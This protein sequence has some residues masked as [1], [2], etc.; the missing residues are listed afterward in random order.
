[1]R[2]KKTLSLDDTL[3]EVT[4]NH[5]CKQDIY[6][7]GAY[8]KARKIYVSHILGSSFTIPLSFPLKKKKSFV[9]AFEFTELHLATSF[10]WFRSVLCRQYFEVCEIHG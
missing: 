7:S 1:M 2:V 9:V 10:G 8:D 6:Y 5:W 3:P 4:Y